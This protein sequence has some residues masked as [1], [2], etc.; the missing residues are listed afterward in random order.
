MT[1]STTS[2]EAFLATIRG[3]HDVHP[4]S[5][6]ATL[7][8][9]VPGWRFTVEGADAVAA[10]FRGWFA[11]PGELEE[12]RRQHTDTGE[13]V[14]FTVTWTENGVPYAARQVHVLDF[15]EQGRVA[16]DHMWCGGR[17]PADLLAKM[18]AT[19]DAG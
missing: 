5:D 1:T 16:H 3:S 13:I 19:R 14:E 11:Q 4:W 17:W 10:Q 12:L 15:D 8:A 9:V 18:G 6:A 7:D 2:I